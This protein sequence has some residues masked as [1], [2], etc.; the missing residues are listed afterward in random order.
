M[1]SP[2]YGATLAT[3][4]PLSRISSEFVEALVVDEP[5]QVAHVDVV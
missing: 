1:S 4:S 3:S 2:G 5:E